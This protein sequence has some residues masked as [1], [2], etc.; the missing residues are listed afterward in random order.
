M[1]MSQFQTWMSWHS[2]LYLCLRSQIIQHITN[3][4]T[5][6]MEL[7]RKEKWVVALTDKFHDAKEKKGL[8]LPC[9][10]TVG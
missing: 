1:Q 4:L 10:S 8:S 3:S 7:N 6:N 5:I 2:A 9:Q